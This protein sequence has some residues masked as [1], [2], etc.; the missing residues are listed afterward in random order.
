MPKLVVCTSGDEFFLNDDSYYFWDSLKGE[1]FLRFGN[2]S[3]IVICYL[4]YISANCQY[5]NIKKINY[6]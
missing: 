1:K 3:L 5:R 6:M 4:L 2:N